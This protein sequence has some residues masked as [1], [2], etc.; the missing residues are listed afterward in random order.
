MEFAALLA[1]GV[2]TLTGAMVTDGWTS[3]KD[4]L[5][6]LFGRSPQPEPA[7]LDELERLRADLIAARDSGDETGAAAV[8]SRIT[9]LLHVRLARLLREQPSLVGELREVIDS[10]G[11]TVTNGTL[12]TGG[13]A[14]VSNTYHYYG[15]PPVPQPVAQGGSTPLPRIGCNP[16]RHYQNNDELLR[17]MDAIWSACRA[18]GTPAVMYLTGLPG[19][20]TSALVLRWLYRNRD[21]LTG[22]QLDA[23]LGRGPTGN[24]PDPT[25]ILQRWLRKLGVPPGRCPGRSPGPSGLLPNRRRGNK[26]PGRHRA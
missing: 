4:R 20:G 26:R 21:T 12:V 6:N 1:T 8:E 2:T 19:I 15:N 18:D 22:P 25:A 16:M 23:C 9:G 5:R 17:R 7:A 10:C 24:P 3:L 14:Q 13:H 11:P